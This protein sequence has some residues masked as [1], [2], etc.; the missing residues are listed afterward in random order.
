ME[1]IQKH[2]S[3]KWGPLERVGQV[4]VHVTTNS[5]ESVSSSTST[6]RG[7]LLFKNRHETVPNSCL[8]EKIHTEN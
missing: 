4:F 8:K 3:S 1:A 6:H 2:T 7:K 5:Q